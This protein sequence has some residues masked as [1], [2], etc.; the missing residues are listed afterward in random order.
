MYIDDEIMEMLS[1]EQ[2]MEL[3]NGSM[4]ELVNTI[5]DVMD[6]LTLSDDVLIDR[7][8]STTFI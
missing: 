8:T 6:S 7:I 2:V 3:F 1:D 5:P 4:D